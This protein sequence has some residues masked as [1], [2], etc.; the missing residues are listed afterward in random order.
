MTSGKIEEDN[1][2]DDNVEKVNDDTTIG[3]LKNQ[4]VK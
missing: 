2:K 3:E 1:V 4:E